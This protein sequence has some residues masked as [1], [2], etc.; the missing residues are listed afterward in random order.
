MMPHHVLA[1][2]SLSITVGTI[3]L[4]PLLAQAGHVEIPAWIGGFAAIL[5]GLLGFFGTRFVQGLDKRDDAQQAQIDACKAENARLAARLQ[6]LETE[7]AVANKTIERCESCLNG[8]NQH[9]II[10]G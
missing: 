5:L 7:L 9:R 2:K 4:S 8:D 3:G 1:A 6:G 10:P